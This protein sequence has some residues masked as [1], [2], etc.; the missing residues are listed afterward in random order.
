MVAS[1]LATAGATLH[2][3]VSL[4]LATLVCGLAIWL[5]DY[6]A[7]RAGA[8]FLFCWIVSLLVYRNDGQNTD[9]GVLAVD[10]AALVYLLWVSLKTRLIWTLLASSFQ[11][12]VVVSHLATAIDLRVA[13]GTFNMSMAIWSYGILLCIAFGAWAGWRERQLYGSGEVFAP[14]DVEQDARA[15]PVGQRQARAGRGDDGL[16]A[17]IAHEIQ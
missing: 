8:G 5:G 11:L 12:I 10:I 14:V 15:E 17:D 1:E 9:L 4:G 2:V 13:I 16:G 7:R 3:Y 6:A